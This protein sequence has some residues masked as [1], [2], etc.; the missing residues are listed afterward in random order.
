MKE[1]TRLKTPVIQKHSWAIAWLEILQ[2]GEREERRMRN[3]QNII[4]MR[5]GCS[6]TSKWLGVPHITGKIASSM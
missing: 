5:R 6:G 3:M 1:G 2:S 4:H